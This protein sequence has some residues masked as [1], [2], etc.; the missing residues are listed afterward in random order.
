MKTG[1]FGINHKYSLFSDAYQFFTEMVDCQLD[2]RQME[3]LI[4]HES[5]RHSCRVKQ[6][7]HELFEI[8]W[9][10]YSSSR[11]QRDQTNQEAVALKDKIYRN[12][13]CKTLDDT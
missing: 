11:I 4:R 6:D 3:I 12:R 2:S 5:Q 10:T 8:H 9:L 13:K 7:P 1:W